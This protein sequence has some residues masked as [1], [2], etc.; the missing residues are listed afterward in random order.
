VGLNRFRSISY[1]GNPCILC[2]SVFLN[3]EVANWSLHGY[4]PTSQRSQWHLCW[5]NTLYTRMHI[6]NTK[7]Q[8]RRTLQACNFQPPSNV[9]PLPVATL[10]L[11]VGQPQGGG[12]NAVLY[13]KTVHAVDR[14]QYTVTSMESKRAEVQHQNLSSTMPIDNARW[15]F[16]NYN[17]IA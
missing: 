5:P 15:H 1:F 4:T 16:S 3:S 9:V 6:L 14:A 7:F 10:R 17:W 2:I 13:R 8:T 11:G 12:G